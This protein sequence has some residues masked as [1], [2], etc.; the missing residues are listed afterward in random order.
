MSISDESSKGI[1]ENYSPH[2]FDV[3]YEIHEDISS[4]YPG[5]GMGMFEFN[6]YT[7]E[8]EMTANLL[9]LG[10]SWDLEVTEYADLGCCSSESL[11]GT[12]VA[13]VKD[14]AGFR[15]VGKA[16]MRI[17]GTVYIR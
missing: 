12:E 17:H 14:V 4:K 13:V 9:K 16:K 15:S 7:G 3:F 6:V 10:E 11:G 5:D 2:S 8:M 1:L